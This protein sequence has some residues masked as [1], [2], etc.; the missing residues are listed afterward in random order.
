[1]LLSLSYALSSSTPFYDGL[2]KPRIDP[3][4]ELSKG[5]VCN[6]AY[7]T[8]SN[9]CGTHVDAPNHFNPTG[10]KITEFS[11]EEL[12]FRDV[13]EYRL[14]LKASELIDAEHLSGLDASYETC[15]A[16]IL[17]SGFGSFRTKDPHA[18]VHDNP[19][20][21]KRGAEAL[22]ERL[23]HLKALLV[24]FPSMSATQ[25]EAEGAEAHR[26]FL[27][28]EG[29]GERTILLVED[30]A[31]PDPLP[32]IERLFIVPWMFEGL[33]SAPCTVWAETSK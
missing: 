6:S 28:C 11:P 17:Y 9:H 25:H 3:L 12:V 21:S 33:D 10:R 30:C 14:P 24:D 4:Y 27:G 2:Q 13:R 1:M 32:A 19:G 7:F 15:T 31:V 5:D 20:F 26:V 18:Y 29:Y 23:P 8:T 22:M 16:L